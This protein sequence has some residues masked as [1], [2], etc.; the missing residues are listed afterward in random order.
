MSVGVSC[1]IT[2]YSE[3]F[4]REQLAN[5]FQYLPRSS[6]CLHS[7]L[8][9]LHPKWVA[10]FPSRHSFEGASEMA[11]RPSQFSRGCFQPAGLAQRLHN[12]PST[13][14]SLSRTS[15][16]QLQGSRRGP[17]LCPLSFSHTVPEV[18]FLT[19]S[20]SSESCE[21]RNQRAN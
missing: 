13:P 10:A 21:I 18:E 15:G 3:E 11:P 8:P 2:E 6:P 14:L 17:H 12:L 20:F 5:L 9:S 4:C 1:V 16:Q 7:C 19:T